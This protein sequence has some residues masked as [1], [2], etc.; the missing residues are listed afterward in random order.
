MTWSVFTAYALDN[1][2]KKDFEK[3]NER[4]ELQMSDWRGFTKFKDFNQYFIKL[5][6]NKKAD[7]TIEDLYPEVINWFTNR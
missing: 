5:Y 7:Q 3:I 6:R 4:V 2:D 1:Y